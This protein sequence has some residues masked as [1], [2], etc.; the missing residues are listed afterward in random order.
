[1]SKSVF[2]SK[3][4][5]VNVLTFAAGLIVFTQDHA[6]LVQ[7]PDLVALAAGVLALVNV[8]LRF[9]TDKPVTL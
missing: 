4:I 7:N 8:A 9:L 2:K 6:L 5:W 3:T 1:M